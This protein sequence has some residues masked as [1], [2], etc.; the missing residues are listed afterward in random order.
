LYKNSVI[1]MGT[2]IYNKLPD[3]MKEIDSYETFKKKLKSVLLPHTL[4]SVEEFLSL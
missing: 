2:K 3:Y 4:Y 1:N